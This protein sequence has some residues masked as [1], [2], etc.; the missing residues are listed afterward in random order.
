MFNTVLLKK[1]MS[2]FN[3]TIIYLNHNNT[4]YMSIFNVLT[5]VHYSVF[6]KKKNMLHVC[7]II[8]Y[9]NGK[10]TYYLII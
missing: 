6:K 10:I 2:D 9:P 8:E 1:I 3:T 4:R 5:E 7:K